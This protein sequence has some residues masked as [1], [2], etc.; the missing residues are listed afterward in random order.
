MTGLKL[1]PCSGTHSS[2]RMQLHSTR[3][4]CSQRWWTLKKTET[5]VSESLVSKWDA[6]GETWDQ[7]CVHGWTFTW[8]RCE[9]QKG[10]QPSVSL[11]SLIL[12][13]LFSSLWQT[14]GVVWPTGLIVF[15]ATALTDYRSQQSQW[16]LSR[17][18]T[19]VN[20]LYFPTSYH[21]KTSLLVV[22]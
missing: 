22:L 3:T 13:L 15:L 20:T 17:M 7:L 19:L 2:R 18:W 9:G 5:G 1:F 11:R 6:W 14:S 21:F 8:T 10:R 4:W 12:L 16:R